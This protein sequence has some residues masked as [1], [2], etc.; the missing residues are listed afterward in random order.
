VNNG[1]PV[2]LG[3]VSGSTEDGAYT[4]HGAIVGVVTK[5]A[6]AQV[7]IPSESEWYKAAYYDP[8]LNGG[9]G[10]Y[11]SDAAQSN[12][13]PGNQIGNLPNQANYLFATGNAN[14]TYLTDVGAFTMSM[15]PYGTFDQMGN[16]NQ[17]TD[18][19]AGANRII[20]GGAWDSPAASYLLST[21]STQGD[22]GQ[23]EDPDSGFRLAMIPEPAVGPSLLG[24]IGLLVAWRRRRSAS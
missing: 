14:G 13:P 23:T 6:N 19:I 4:L 5:N 11:W 15:S 20:R 9:A 10:G 21:F 7:W 18:G 22:P 2:G 1:Q 24:G 16:V 12:L 8:T 3:E 17:W